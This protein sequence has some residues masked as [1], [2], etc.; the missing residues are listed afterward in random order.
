MREFRRALVARIVGD[1]RVSTVGAGSTTTVV[2]LGAGQAASWAVAD[3]AYLGTDVRSITVVDTV[4]DK[5]T[6]EPA[7]SAAP[8]SGT[9][10][11]GGSREWL[12][13][14]SAAKPGIY[15]WGW[16]PS[17]VDSLRTAA[18]EGR[19]V[20]MFGH[21]PASREMFRRQRDELELQL[22]GRNVEFLEGAVQALERLLHGQRTGLVVT[23]HDV[24]D[25]SV[26]STPAF[27]IDEKLRSAIVLVRG[28]IARKVA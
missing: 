23:A 4:L 26:E 25:L 22:F 8:A 12:R 3:I 1:T 14:E 20:V 10:L 2:Q 21:A 5:V 13:Y 6:V 24:W 18:G 16:E 11:K 7:L 19:V 27:R 28:A 15:E 9:Q 17:P